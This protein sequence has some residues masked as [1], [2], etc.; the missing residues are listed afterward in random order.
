[1]LIVL[2]VLTGTRKQTNRV[3][4]CKGLKVEK[5]EQ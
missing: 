1:M 3:E 4:E 5:A 2:Q